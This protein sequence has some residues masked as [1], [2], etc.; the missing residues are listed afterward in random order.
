MRLV[1]AIALMA[2]GGAVGCAPAPT[3]IPPDSRLVPNPVPTTFSL[4]DWATIV[5]E[6]A[7]K[8]L[9]DYDGLARNRETLDRYYALIS[10]MGPASTADQ[11]PTRQD[12]IAYDINA[13]NALMLLIVLED[14][15]R[16]TIYD[17]DLPLPMTGY[18]FVVDGARVRLFDIEQRLLRDS[19]GDVRILFA[20]N[21]GALG[22]PG[23]HYEPFR[24][25]SLERQLREA[26]ANALDDPR[27][28]Q[29]D[30]EQ[31]TL[32]LWLGILSHRDE[33]LDFYQLRRRTPAPSLLSVL[34]ELASPRRRQALNAAIGY[35][36][37]PM[38]FD[39]RLNRWRPGGRTGSPPAAPSE[40]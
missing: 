34:L 10:V 12:Q 13:F 22:G 6:Y 15:Q 28:L 29:V 32:F 9:V 18:Q 19:S 17:L 3:L 4:G 37:R 27:L 25:A 23:L 11:F 7:K 40:S 8:G 1:G 21:R 5:T 16:A 35:H 39:R 31:R 2:L 38:P 14:P 30:H 20:L 24:A 36:I 33:F 26:A